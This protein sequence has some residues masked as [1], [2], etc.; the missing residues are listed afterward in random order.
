MKKNCENGHVDINTVISRYFLY[1]RNT[2]QTSAN[3]S[4]AEL[5]YKRKL[6]TRFHFISKETLKQDEGKVIGESN[7]LRILY[8]GDQV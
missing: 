1:Y 6:N 8:L 7:Y 3:L 5:L 4:P 2:H